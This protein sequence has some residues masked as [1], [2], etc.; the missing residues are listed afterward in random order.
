MK[1][2][3]TINEFWW[4]NFGWRIKEFF[5]S[6]QKLI[7][8]FPIIW[9]DRD[10]DQSF[11]FNMLEIKLTNMAKY[12]RQRDFFVGQIRE[13]EK[14]ELCVRLIKKI[15]DD[16]YSYEYMDILEK[17]YGEEKMYVDPSTHYLKWEYVDKKYTKKELESINEEKV[18]L[19]K[20]SQAKQQKAKRILFTLI[21]RNIDRWWD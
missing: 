3:K 7:I 4:D 13:A 20:R 1:V 19:M 8:W 14:M 6:V 11:I 17:K 21:E 18:Y 16:F 5:R 15:N 2:L 10:W 12:F 9:K